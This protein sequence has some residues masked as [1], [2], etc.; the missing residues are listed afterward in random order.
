M[1]ILRKLIVYIAYT[2]L[3][4]ALIAFGVLFSFHQALGSPGRI[5]NALD[6]SGIYNTIGATIVNQATSSANSSL[7][8]SGQQ[9]VQ[10]AISKA[11]PPEYL[12]SQTNGALQNIYSWLQGKTNNLSFS[13][14]L[15]SVKNKLADNMAE[16]AQQRAA[17]LPACTAQD[18]ASMDASNIDP[19]AVTC[20]PPNVTPAQI[21]D[22]ARQQVLTSN[23]YKTGKLT[24]DNINQNGKSLQQQLQPVA[25]V[26]KDI[27]RGLIWTGVG[28]VLLT[29]MVILL[30]RPWQQGTKRVSII[31]LSIGFTSAALAFVTGWLLHAVSNKLTQQSSANAE[32]QGKVVKVIQLLTSD[33][34]NWWIGYG[35]ALALAGIMGLIVVRIKRIT[36]PSQN[37]GA[38]LTAE[39]FSAPAV[40]A[41][42]HNN[43][44]PPTPPTNTIIG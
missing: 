10:N 31:F 11:I 41:N 18:M 3:P 37:S 21:G 23:L 25:N 38:G 13:I 29:A 36:P 42:E 16:E 44:Q 7:D 8:S 24:S 32:I 33:L 12:K 30:S 27:W 43:N 26:Y 40:S 6:Q 15:S 14:D 39:S 20:L 9:A 17:S 22:L 19:L 34:R 2:L 4:T 28:I 1:H 35:I 5:E